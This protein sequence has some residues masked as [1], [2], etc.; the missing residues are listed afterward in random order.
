MNFTRVVQAGVVAGI[1]S[2]FTS[3]L[4]TGT[5]FHKYQRL[6][7]DT[8]RPEGPAQYAMSSA[9]NVVECVG[10]ALLLAWSSAFPGMQAHGWA[11]RGVLFGLVCWC[12]LLLPAT[13]VQAVYV[14]LHRGFVA[15]AALDALVLCLMAGAAGA[16]AVQ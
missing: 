4:I 15:G 5:I 12:A 11:G 16:W 10:I 13:L 6:T 14:K 3:W 2:I 7:P 9:L 1:V 8:W